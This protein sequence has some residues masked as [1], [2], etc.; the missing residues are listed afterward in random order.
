MANIRDIMVVKALTPLIMGVMALIDYLVA[1]LVARVTNKVYF[2]M[3]PGRPFNGIGSLMFTFFGAIAAMS[4][5]LWRC[6]SSP[7][8][9]RA[10]FSDASIICFESYVWNGMLVISIWA[11]MVYV[12]QVLL[13]GASCGEASV[14]AAWQERPYAGHRRMP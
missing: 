11:V 1:V 5:E 4:V 14:P 6:M 3:E 9:Q 10:M 2:R 8:G 7:N 13:A 12:S